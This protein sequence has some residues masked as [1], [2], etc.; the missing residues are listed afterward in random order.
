MQTTSECGLFDT[1]GMATRNR[2]YIGRIIWFLGGIVLGI[3][4]SSNG[5]V[6]AQLTDGDPDRVRIVA[7]VAALENII[8]SLAVDTERSAIGIAELNER[9]AGLE[10]RISS[11]EKTGQ[12]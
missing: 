10:R 12:Q 7:F 5:A 2:T 6:Q 1:H 9:M 11:L 8:V 3:F 4:L